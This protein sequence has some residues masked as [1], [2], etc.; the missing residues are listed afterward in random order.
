MR[1]VFVLVLQG[2]IRFVYPSA[3][4][5]KGLESIYL[6]VHFCGGLWSE[7]QVVGG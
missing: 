2:Y 5:C 7:W 3:R 6:F 4:K 1:R